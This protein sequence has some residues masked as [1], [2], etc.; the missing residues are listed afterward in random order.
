MSDPHDIVICGGGVIGSAVAYFLSARSDRPARITV[1]ERDPSY[2]TSSTALSAASIRQQFST[3]ENIRISQFGIAFLKAVPDLLAVDGD[4]PEIGLQEAGY[5]FLA[6]PAGRQILEDNHARQ[7]ALGAEIALLDPAAL[8]ARFAWLHTDDLAGGAL[9]LSGEGW[10]DA[11]GLMMALKRKAM[12]QGVTYRHD[13]V[14]ALTCQGARICAVHLADGTRLPCAVLVNAAGPRAAHLAA[15]AGITLPIFPRKRHVFTFQCRTPTPGM[16]LTVDPS[17]MYVR[18]EG[19]GYICGISPGRG[20]PDPD[21]LDL[22]V[23]SRLFEERLWP[24]LAHRVP[25]FEAIKPGRAWAGHYAV[26]PFDHNAVI[27]PHPQIDNFLFANGFSG[28]GL[29]QAPAVG[30]AIAEWIILGRYDSLD[31]SRLGFARFAA[32]APIRERNV[33]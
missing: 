19:A 33:V 26:T 5:L 29:Q 10:F 6:T 27:G 20:D 28:H 13:E 17:G 30:R 3:E 22:E 21:C 7:T 4:R 11:Y 32:D 9:G 16:P 12:A 8:K 15:M 25:A 24:L 31:L 1:I 23:D 18:P 14:V 2:A